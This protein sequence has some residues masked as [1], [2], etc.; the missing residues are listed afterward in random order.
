MVYAQVIV[1]QLLPGRE[2]ALTSDDPIKE[3]ELMRHPQKSKRIG[4]ISK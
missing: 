3:Q 1:I 2:L 4:I